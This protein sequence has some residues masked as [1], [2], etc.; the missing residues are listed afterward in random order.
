[1][2]ASENVSM[3]VLQTR[4]LLV[5]KVVGEA[6][7]GTYC[8]MASND[9]GKTSFSANLIILGAVFCVPTSVSLNSPASM[10][11]LPKWFFIN[12]LFLV[13]NFNLKSF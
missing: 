1:M 13:F 12:F 2:I 11:A 5:F 3:V 8:A 9:F 4:H 10:L 6:D 7:E